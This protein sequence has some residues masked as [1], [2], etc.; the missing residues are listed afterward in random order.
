VKTGGID[1]EYGGALGGVISAVTKSG[2]N[3]FRG[4]AH[5]YYEGN[6]ISAGPVKR[7]VLNPSDDTTVG[8]FQ[9][10]KQEDNRSEI[11][12]SLGGPIVRDRLF[13]FGSVSPRLV[14][15]TN[16]YLFSEGKVPGSFDRSDD[17]WQAFGKVTYSNSRVAANGRVLYAD[18]VGRPAPRVRR[19]R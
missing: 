5:Y 19:S 15:R 1:A 12:G 9:D 11:G 14:R 7:L 10:S 13:F 6:A 16:D 18:L 8:Y 2:G 3:M 4:E 17:I